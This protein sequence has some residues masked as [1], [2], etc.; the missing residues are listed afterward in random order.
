MSNAIWM[1]GYQILSEHIDR[2]DKVFHV[3]CVTTVD[4]CP[5]CG[6]IGRMY[7]HGTSSATYQDAPSY[8]HRVRIDVRV[9]RWICRECGG[10]SVQPL[11]FMDTTRQMTKRC[12]DYIAREGVEATFSALARQVGVHEK[13]VRMIC[14]EA[15]AAKMADWKVEAP[16]MLGMDELML[17][18]APRAIFVDIGQRRTIEILPTRKHRPVAYWLDTL[19]KKDRTHLVAIDMWRPY[20]DLVK[21]FLPNATV[22]IDKF[23]IVRMANQALDR[24]R[25]DVRRAGTT[26]KARRNPRANRLL[27][28]TGRRNLDPMAIVWLDGMLQNNPLFKAAWS[29]KEGFYDIWDA[30]TR[31]DAE[32]LYDDWKA[33]LDPSIQPAFSKLITACTNWRTEI[34]AY[35]DY[36]ITN[37]FTENRNGIIKIAN[38]AGRGYSFDAIRAKALLAK[39]YKIST[40]ICCSR[41]IPVKGMTQFTYVSPV[42]GEHVDMPCCGDCRYAFHKFVLPR[43]NEFD[44]FVY[45][46]ATSEAE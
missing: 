33:S 45:R 6:V 39:P 22:V 43:K 30:K 35:F 9:Q 34:F 16:I 2:D 4:A 21:A 7:R 31:A 28:Q 46:Y 8:G 41:E 18:G 5:K 3:E 12:V 13:T 29:A 24:V 44:D 37:A 26:V 15:F 1:P 14:H 17:A 40:C 11:P 23:H 38:R 19:P 32:R 10:T 36:P 20:R 42:D 25:N 27:M